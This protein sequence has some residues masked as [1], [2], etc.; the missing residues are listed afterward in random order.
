MPSLA[1]PA[2]RRAGARGFDVGTDL[3]V[4]AL[5]ALVGL[6]VL[7][8]DG[9][10]IQI[11]L[12]GGRD[13]ALATAPVLAAIAAARRRP[14]TALLAAALAVESSSERRRRRVAPPSSHAP[15]LRV[16]SANLLG[17]NPRVEDLGRELVADAADVVVVQELT[18]PHADGLRAAGLPD[19]MPYHV[20]DPQPAFYGSGL[21]SR[22]PITDAEVFEVHG[23]GMAAATVHGPVGAVQVVAVHVVNPAA[24]QGMTSAWRTQLDWL[25]EHVRRSVVPVVLAGDYNATMD[26]RSL[27]V[28]PAVGMVDAHDAAGR[29][30]GLTWPRRSYRG[31]GRWPALPLMRLDHVFVPPTL[32][33]RAVRTAVSAGS[34]HRRVIAD[35]VRIV[36]SDPG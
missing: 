11:A 23:V 3:A 15:G 19:A 8:R 6:R 22:W 36:R 29:G 21:Y 7:P 1:R 31:A 16:V 24:R 18:Q 35:L 5:T 25:A 17:G 27:R 34:D 33:V 9:H 14:A 32:G 26:H 13:A 20:L 30:L 10:R 12:E 2:G 28:L 4:G